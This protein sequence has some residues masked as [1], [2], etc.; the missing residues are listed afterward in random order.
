M[1]ESRN[2]YRVLVGRAEGKRPLG[3][4]RR[5]WEDNIKIDLRELGYDDKEWI[6]LAQDRDQWRAYMRAAM[7]LRDDNNALSE[8]AMRISYKICHKIAKKLKT[9]NE[10]EF[11]KRCLIILAD[12]LCPQQVG[13]VEAI[14][15]SRRTVVRRLQYVRMGYPVTIFYCKIHV[16]QTKKKKKKNKKKK[17]KVKTKIEV[18]GYW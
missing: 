17:R 6:N 14:R 2:A 15:L 18:Q 3:R 5:R 7:N 8:S 12:E 11:I 16:D 10:G 1:G 13:E 4:P 9:F